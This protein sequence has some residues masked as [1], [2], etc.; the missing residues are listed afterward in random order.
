MTQSP[1]VLSKQFRKDSY[2][3]TQIKRSDNCALYSKQKG[4]A[5]PSFETIR[6]KRSKKDYQF[7]SRTNKNGETIQGRLIPAGSEHYPSSEDWGTLGFTH[8]SRSEAEAKYREL[9][10]REEEE[11]QE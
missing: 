9:L 3:F 10:K 8:Q 1:P 2:D 7:P 6:I 4:D 11:Q 5:D